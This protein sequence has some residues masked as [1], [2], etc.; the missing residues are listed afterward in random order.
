MNDGTQGGS[1]MRQYPRSV[2]SVIAA[3]LWLVLAPSVLGHETVV[4]SDPAAGT[5]VAAPPTEVVVTFS[6]ELDPAGSSLVVLDTDGRAV[7]SGE[8]DLAVPDRNVL[9]GSVS[10]SDID[11]TYEV[12]WTAVANDGHVEEGAFSFSVGSRPPNTAL[13]APS[14]LPEIGLALMLAA[15]ATGLRRAS[16]RPAA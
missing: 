6:G 13:H 4:S 9:R 16:R 3:A 8:V 12:R 1:G 15:V 2:A 5:V 14:G 11:A 10:I 7:G